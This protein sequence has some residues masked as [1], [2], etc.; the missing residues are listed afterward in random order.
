MSRPRSTNK[1]KAVWKCG[2]IFIW[3]VVIEE[4]TSML[5]VW[6]L[7][8]CMLVMKVVMFLAARQVINGIRLRY[9]ALV[10]KS[11]TKKKLSNAV[12]HVESQNFSKR[13]N[14]KTGLQQ[15]VP[16]AR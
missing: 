8:Q 5:V 15:S 10:G 9:P 4:V 14:I 11:G 12:L 7:K 6:R 1:H 16:R 13:I 3:G 2:D